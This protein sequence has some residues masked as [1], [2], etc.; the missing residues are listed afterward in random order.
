L[1]FFEG[2]P[3]ISTSDIRKLSDFRQNATA[4]LD[5][6]AESGGV[7]ILTVNGEAKGVVMSPKVFDEINERIER[8]ETTASVR[9]GLADVAA[10]RMWPARKAIKAL[11]AE[12]GLKLESKRRAK[13]VG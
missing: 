7:E 8:L 11:A 10:G 5:R 9:R 1:V 12:L 13:K 3:L 2:V 4:H 6:L